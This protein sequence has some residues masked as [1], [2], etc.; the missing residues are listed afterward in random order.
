MCPELSQSLAEAW[1]LLLLPFLWTGIGAA[2]GWVASLLAPPHIKRTAIAAVAFPNSTGLPITLLTALSQVALTPG[3]GPASQLRSF[4]LML[5]IY[6]VTYPVLQWGLGGRILSEKRSDQ[7]ELLEAGECAP[8]SSQPKTLPV[9][10]KELLKAIFSPPVVAVCFGVLIGLSPPVHS[11]FVDR[12]DFDNDR[13]LEFLFN[14]IRDFGQAAV[15]MQ[16]MVLGASL[17]SIPSFASIQ[18]P[19]TIAVTFCKLV[20]HPAAGFGIIY[21]VDTAGGISAIAGSQRP[22]LIIVACIMCACPT[23]SNMQ[24]MAEV[25]GGLECKQALS[26]MTFLMYCFAPIVLTFWLVVAVSMAQV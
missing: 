9:K 4:L 25:S 22:S 2:A 17:A 13:P 10:V 5:S 21:L 18:W 1:P 14:A 8:A 24:V 3:V 19:A 6:Q 23:S 20:V 15:P 7:Q 26:A 11:I 16:M 12:N